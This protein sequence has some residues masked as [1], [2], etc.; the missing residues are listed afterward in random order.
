MAPIGS[1][2]R[3]EQVEGRRRLSLGDV[4]CIGYAMAQE[5]EIWTAD[6]AWA[7]LDLPVPV[8]VIR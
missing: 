7:D 8:R 1:L 2:R 4:C 5:M 6:R 3:W